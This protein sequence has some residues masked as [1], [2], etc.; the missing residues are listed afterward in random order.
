[1]GCG[2]GP[3]AR[4]CTTRRH[5]PTGARH[6]WR[7]HAQLCNSGSAARFGGD[8]QRAWPAHHYCPLISGVLARCH[9]LA[10]HCIYIGGTGICLRLID[11]H[12]THA[13]CA[14]RQIR[15]VAGCICIAVS[16]SLG[17]CSWHRAVHPAAPVCPVCSLYARRF[18]LLA[19]MLVALPFAY[20][21][22][23]GRLAA[24]AATH[25]R[26]VPA[27]HSWL[28]AFALDH[29]AGPRP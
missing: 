8:C 29:P 28:A 21:V 17:N 24:L 26:F 1:M 20:R 6:R 13:A 15:L 14:V 27:W 23:E 16:R 18:V 22:I 12:S 7:H 9:C 25:D 5:Q 3:P 11:G 4:N 2:S 10:C 19:N